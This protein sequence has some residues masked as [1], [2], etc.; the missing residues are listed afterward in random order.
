MKINFYSSSHFSTRQAIEMVHAQHLQLFSIFTQFDAFPPALTVARRQIILLLLHS[1]AEN[2]IGN[3]SV[4]TKSLPTKKKKK[5]TAQQRSN[6]NTSQNMR[7]TQIVSECECS[8]KS[9]V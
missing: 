2:S 7:N 4:H 5:K 1:L 9:N 3:R 8:C 6:N